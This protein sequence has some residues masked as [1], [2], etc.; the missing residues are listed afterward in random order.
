MAKNMLTHTFSVI[1][2]IYVY[3]KTQKNTKLLV[4]DFYQHKNQLVPPSWQ[5]PYL[6]V[7]LE[8]VDRCV[9]SWFM[10]N[11]SVS[12]ITETMTQD[13]LW[14]SSA[15]IRIIGCSNYL[16]IPYTIWWLHFRNICQLVSY[17][18]KFIR[19]KDRKSIKIYLS[20]KFS[21]RATTIKTWERISF[22]KKVSS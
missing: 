17:P 12:V 6:N 16:L 10:T 2:Y 22:I 19:Q 4:N 15:L 13:R 8:I 20:H 1:F 7:R 5:W 11:V 18:E 3:C 14:Q 21:S 9:K